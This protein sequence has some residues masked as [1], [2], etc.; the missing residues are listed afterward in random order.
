ME[1]KVPRLG[2]GPCKWDRGRQHGAF[3]RRRM[4]PSN[5]AAGPY[6]LCPNSGLGIAR[7][8]P[9]HVPVLEYGLCRAGTFGT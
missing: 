1:N 4:R 7:V 2:A 6:P 9:R 5:T 8:L 3:M